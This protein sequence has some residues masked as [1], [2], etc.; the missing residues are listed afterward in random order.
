MRNIEKHPNNAY[1]IT[2]YLNKEDRER[3]NMLSQLSG[4]SCGKVLAKLVHDTLPK[5]RMAEKTY[6][7]RELTFE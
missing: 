4:L 5:A 2:I 3:L 7:V 6:V 1:N